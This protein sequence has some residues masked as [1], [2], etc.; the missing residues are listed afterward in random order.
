MRSRLPNSRRDFLKAGA[1][2]SLVIGFGL[3]LP[4]RLEAAAAKTTAF[5]PNAFL[6]ITS[7]NQVTVICGSAEM[8]QGVLTAM[9]MLVAEQLDCDWSRIQVEQAPVD[10]AYN[11]PLFGMQATGGSTTIR[12]FYEPM[13][14]AGAAARDMLIQAAA[15]RWKTGTGLCF[16]RDG[17]IVHESRKQLS[18]G[19]LVADAAKLPVPDQPKMEPTGMFRLV[20]KPIT[21]STARPRSTV[22]PSTASTRSCPACWSR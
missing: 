20:G 2:S 10:P 14:K 18:F 7:D 15:Q 8:G 1:A 22:R 6:R 9:A 5:T 13:Q 3:P 4:G 21:G 16:A 17:Y 11:N 12:A 19:Q